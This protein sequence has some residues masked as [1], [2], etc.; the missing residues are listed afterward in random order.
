MQGS[1]QSAIVASV[2]TPN[3]LTVQTDG[4]KGLV[5]FNVN[6]DP[7]WITVTPGVQEPISANGRLAV[8]LAAGSTDLRLRYRPA[9][10]TQGVLVT[11]LMITLGVAML[12]RGIHQRRVT[13]S[14]EA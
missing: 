1:P 5:I 9:A 10:F 2:T 7:G 6:Y 3:S 8:R 12:G 11:A 4:R 13:S 14:G